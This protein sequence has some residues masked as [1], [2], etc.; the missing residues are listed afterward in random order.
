MIRSS[1]PLVSVTLICY[2]QEKFISESIESVLMQKTNFDFEVI[3]GDDGSSDRTKTIISEYASNDNRIVFVNR[4][5]NLG[6]QENI[7]DIFERCSG[8]Y[9]A[10]MEGDDYWIDEN[11][12]QMQFDFLE[13]NDDCTVCFTNSITFTDSFFENGKLLYGEYGR[14]AP[15]KKIF[16]LDEYISKGYSI[17]NNTKMFRR[18]SI[19]QN[20]PDIFFKSIQWDWLLH[21]LSGT[22]GNYG[23]IDKTTLAYRRHEN[24][25]INKKNSEKIFLDAIYLVY[26]INSILPDRYWKYFK[27]PL[28]EMNS[29]SFY[30]LRVGS[31]SKFIKWYSKWLRHVSF[32]SIIFRDEFYK[33]R[34][35]VFKYDK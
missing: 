7:A 30:Y 14:K 9:I 19:P 29:L 33:F 21:V 25:I 31:Y 4:I 32:K 20:L 17:P 35:S 26:N 11:K 34:N 27:H 18:E 16:N 2:N 24:T 13:E 1:V 10:L 23:Y 28:H 5:Q 8:K 12:L 22:K 6:L 3:I 15:P